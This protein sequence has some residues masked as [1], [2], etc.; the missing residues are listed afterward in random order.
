MSR[1]RRV[2]NR[3]SWLTTDTVFQE[4]STIVSQS[5]RSSRKPRKENRAKRYVYKIVAIEQR[6]T[7]Y[8]SSIR[9]TFHNYRTIWKFGYSLL[10][11]YARLSFRVSWNSDEPL[12]PMTLGYLG[13]SNHGSNYD[14]FWVRKVTVLLRID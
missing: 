8:I 2:E 1:R 9:E 10:C 11:N 7:R 14:L 6:G 5:P 13:I 3:E 12:E 4:L